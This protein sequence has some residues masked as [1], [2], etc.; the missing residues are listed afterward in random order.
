MFVV[1]KGVQKYKL[2]FI[3]NYPM[4]PSIITRSVEPLNK[5]HIGIRSS[6]PC[7]SKVE[8]LNKGHIGMSLVVQWN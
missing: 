7:S 2:Q 1:G 6:V 5:G 8:P 4:D 3:E